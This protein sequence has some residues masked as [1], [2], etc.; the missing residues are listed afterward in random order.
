MHIHRKRWPGGSDYLSRAVPSQ[1]GMTRQL[2]TLL[3]AP[4]QGLSCATPISASLT[5]QT[6]PNTASQGDTS[7]TVSLPHLPMEDTCVQC[8]ELKI[9]SLPMSTGE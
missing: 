6:V 3:C 7:L 9:N 8:L 1:E 4:S 2:R 5:L